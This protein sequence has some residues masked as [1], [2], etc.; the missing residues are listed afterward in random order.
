MIRCLKEVFKVVFDIY[1]YSMSR[2]DI[3]IMHTSLTGFQMYEG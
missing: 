3:M 1:F 2:F